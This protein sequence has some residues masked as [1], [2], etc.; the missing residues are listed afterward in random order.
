MSFVLLGQHR[1]GTNYLLDLIRHH[2]A[3]DTI[4]EPFSMHLDFFREDETP[5][6]SEDYEVDILHKC[7]QPFPETVEYIKDLNHWLNFPFPNVRGFKETA[8]FEKW[9]WINRV[10]CYDKLI[11]IVRDP[12]ATIASV[13]RR[14]LHRSWWDYKSRLITYYNLTDVRSVIDSPLLTCAAILKVRMGY[15]RKIMGKE[16]CLV[17]RLEDIVNSNGSEVQRVMEY[18]GLDLHLEQIE[19]ITETSSETRDFTY[20]NYRQTD[21][22]LHSWKKIIKGKDCEMVENYLSEELEFFNYK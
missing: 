5:W 11:I 19:F 10:L 4:N 15:L 9:D 3:V 18:L 17:V 14:D 21:Q 8:L 16:S 20:S 7:L 12:R 1:S 2:P 22:V 6:S 13:L